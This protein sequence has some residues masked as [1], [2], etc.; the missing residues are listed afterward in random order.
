MPLLFIVSYCWFIVQVYGVKPVESQIGVGLI[1][2]GI[3]VYYAWH[4]WTVGHPQRKQ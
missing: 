2:L 4:L 3:P 1:L